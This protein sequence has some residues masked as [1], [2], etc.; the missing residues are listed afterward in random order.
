MCEGMILSPPMGTNDGPRNGHVHPLDLNM[1]LKS[2]E[3]CRNL[4]PLKVTQ[5][6]R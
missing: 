1:D 2:V 5:L 3:E 6:G 4:L